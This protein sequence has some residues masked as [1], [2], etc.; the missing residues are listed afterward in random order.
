[1]TQTVVLNAD[2]TYLNTVGMKKA[3]KL[4]IKEKA[5]VLAEG[6]RQIAKGFKVPLVLRLVY[7]VR[8]VYKNKVPYSRKNVLIRDRH[9]CQ[10]CGAKHN[11]TID[12]VLPVTKGGKSTFLNC[13]TACFTCNNRKG[14][15]E[16]YEV[17]M[18]LRK[19]PYEPTII[20]FLTIKMRLLG[21][22]ATLRD[23]GVF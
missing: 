5:E 22:E 6:E 15:K 1:M 4:L 12:H 11:L 20:D 18:Q 10:Y 14:H 2:Y 19:Q 23:L 3:V 9:T 8:T 13:V 21:V 17:G 7:F 16:L